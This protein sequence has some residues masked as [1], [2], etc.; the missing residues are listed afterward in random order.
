M[1]RS[2]VVICRSEGLSAPPVD[3]SLLTSDQIDYDFEL[4]S[5][6]PNLITGIGD[7]L[8]GTHHSI[9]CDLLLVLYDALLTTPTAPLPIIIDFGA[10]SHIM[11][12][13]SL[14]VNFYPMSG[15]VTL[16]DKSLQLPITGSG[17]TRLTQLGQALLVPKLSFGLIS[18]SVLNQLGCVTFI[19]NRSLHQLS[20]RTHEG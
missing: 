20:A 3:S 9:A 10:S 2:L 19:A 13:I 8:L 17:T 5:L 16:G 6:Q 7:T 15:T 14:L 4:L 11:P 1:I 18:I 12:L